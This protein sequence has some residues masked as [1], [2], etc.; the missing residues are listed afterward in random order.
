MG[1]PRHAGRDRIR[2][3]VGLAKVLSCE[4]RVEVFVELAGGPGRVCDLAQRLELD[5]TLVSH[6]LRTLKDAGLV[7]QDPPRPHGEYKL[8]RAASIAVE[9]EMLRVA[10]AVGPAALS[11]VDLHGSG[12][13][14]EFKPSPANRVAA[15]RAAGVPG[16]PDGAP[17][18]HHSTR[19]P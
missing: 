15:H 9:P 14:A 7:E 6:H 18:V 3:V 11:L 5:S 4:V 10:A 8:S 1:T 19:A 2:A 13:L 17:T 12:Q 16:Q